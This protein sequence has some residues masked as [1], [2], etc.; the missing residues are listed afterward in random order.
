MKL[1][2]GSL[3]REGFSTVPNVTWDH[4]GGLEH[5]RRELNSFIVRPIKYPDTYEVVIKNN[6]NPYIVKIT[7]LFY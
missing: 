5:L 6:Y 7:S 3:T 2:Q 1:V 4:V